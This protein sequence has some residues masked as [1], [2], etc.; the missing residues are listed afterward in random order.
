MGIATLLFYLISLF[1]CTIF[2]VEIYITYNQQEHY[3]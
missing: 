1:E 3:T 2:L